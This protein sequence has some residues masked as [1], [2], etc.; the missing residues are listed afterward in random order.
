MKHLGRS[1]FVTK[2][3]HSPLYTNVDQPSMIAIQ[4]Q[5]IVLELE[6]KPMLCRE[7]TQV[8]SSFEEMKDLIANLKEGQKLA[9]QAKTDGDDADEEDTFMNAVVASEEGLPPVIMFAFDDYFPAV[10]ATDM[11]VRVCLSV[12]EAAR[13]TS[14]VFHTSLLVQTGLLG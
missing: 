1:F 9:E 5:K 13:R 12:F 10:A 11:L 6:R 8:V 2:L 14:S 3:L 7:M 4:K